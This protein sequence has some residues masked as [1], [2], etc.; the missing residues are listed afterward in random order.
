MNAQ[1]RATADLMVLMTATLSGIAI[2]ILTMMIGS[3]HGWTV[4]RLSATA[5]VLAP[6]GALT[7]CYR[8]QPFMKTIARGVLLAFLAI[9][10]VIV[11]GA[12]REL[13]HDAHAIDYLNPAAAIIWGTLWLFWQVMTLLAAWKH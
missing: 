2:V 10:L 9:D 4:L 11:I 3:G 6:A 12:L 5:I 8:D 13:G 1:S 7:W